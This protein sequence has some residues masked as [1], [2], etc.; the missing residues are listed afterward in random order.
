MGGRL[1]FWTFQDGKV[2]LFSQACR[3]FLRKS[4]KEETFGD[5]RAKKAEFG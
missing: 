4:G 2:T 5:S 3:M 1:V